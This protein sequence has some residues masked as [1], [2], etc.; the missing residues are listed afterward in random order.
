MKP[1]FRSALFALGASMGSHPAAALATSDSIDVFLAICDQS[2]YQRCDAPIPVPAS[3]VLAVFA[4]AKEG[5]VATNVA[6]ELAAAGKSA[7][8]DLSKKAWESERSLAIL[9]CDGN[10]ADAWMLTEPD[11]SPERLV[12]EW[13]GDDFEL[14]AIACSAPPQI[15]DKTPR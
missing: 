13:T 6:I 3:R 4:P 15:I 2:A 14:S 12:F 5:S 7:M 10:I 8:A 9:R 11:Y 1:S